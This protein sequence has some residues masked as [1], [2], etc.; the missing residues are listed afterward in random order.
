MDPPLCVV[1]VQAVANHLKASLV[2]L[3]GEGR[4]LEGDEVEEDFSGGRFQL[5]RDDKDLDSC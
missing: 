5:V 3:D 1:C 4:V 2:Q